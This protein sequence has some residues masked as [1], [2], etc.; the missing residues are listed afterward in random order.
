MDF[1]R[2]ADI[3]IPLLAEID[4][5]GGEAKPKDLYDRLAIHFGLSDAQKQ[6]TLGP[7]D[8][9]NKWRNIVQWTRSNLVHRKGE[10]AVSERG[11]WR[12]TDAGKIR[13]RMHGVPK[14]DLLES[15]ES[16]S[17]R[18]P[19]W[20]R[21][22][23]ILALALYLRKGLLD[24]KSTEVLQ[25]SR[26]LNALANSE[27]KRDVEKFR[28]PN[29]VA[30]KL[31]NFSSID[32]NHKGKGLSAG[33]KNDRS[34]WDEFNADLTKIEAAEKLILSKIE[35]KSKTKDLYLSADE[36]EDMA[37]FEPLDM[38][39]ARKRTL[40]SIALRRG[41]S[42]FRKKLLDAYESRCTITASDAPDAL[43]AAHI[44]PYRNENLN[45]PAN[46]LLLRAD[47]HVLFDLGL[48][49][50]NP[51][52]FEIVISKRLSKTVYSELEGRKIALPKNP[53]LRPNP[54]ALKQHF[55]TVFVG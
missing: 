51:T 25:L 8:K 35:R 14:S 21:E 45:H 42:T 31:A 27:F 19:P 23:L 30:M 49:S 40:Q 12:I 15:S 47:I 1:P 43:E 36:P 10:L 17:K 5:L 4:K 26:T 29:G 38:V 48:I 3:E 32:P 50:V 13:L 16:K 22:E 6:K 18:N 44:I 9:R 20:E 39:D 53:N 37:V 52:T 46:G 33:A 24:D 28:N 11:T 34:V 54:D 41:Q 7:N 2:Q 55:L